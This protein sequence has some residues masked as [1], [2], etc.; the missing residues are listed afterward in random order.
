MSEFQTIQLEIDPRGVATLWLDR[1]EKNNAFNAVVID[2]LLQAIDRVGSDPQVRLLVLRGRGRHFCGGADLAWM[3][4]SVDLD[5]QGNLADAQRIAELMAHL[6][7][8]PKPTLAVV[9]GAVFGGGVG[10]VSCCDMAIGSDDA[11][12]CLSEVR[13][14]L[15]PATIAPFVVKAIGQRAARRYSLTAERFDGRRASELG[16]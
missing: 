2:E 3:Q 16:L 12:F 10:L 15:I 4:Q 11:T 13:I 1:A 5:Y 6:Y 7:N 8:L 14:G 9:Q